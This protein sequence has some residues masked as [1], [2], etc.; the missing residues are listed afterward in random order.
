MDVFMNASDPITEDSLAVSL[1]DT[2]TFSYQAVSCN[3]FL[4]NPVIT[5]CFLLLGSLWPGP[6]PTLC[7][8]PLL[9]SLHLVTSKQSGSSAQPTLWVQAILNM[10]AL[11]SAHP[12]ASALLHSSP[13]PTAPWGPPTA[14]HYIK[15]AQSPVEAH[16]WL[17]VKEWGWV[18]VT[19][20]L[21]FTP[22]NLF[23]QSLS[24]T[25]CKLFY[26][27]TGSRA[28]DSQNQNLRLPS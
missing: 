27:W 9:W 22:K 20:W 8:Y 1:M 11:S 24:S 16:S 18:T 28:Q 14:G 3:S 23:Y 10:A 17:E 12:S 6:S 26:P 5:S 21:Q 2:Y 19:A 4:K 25:F 15:L 7:W 13:N